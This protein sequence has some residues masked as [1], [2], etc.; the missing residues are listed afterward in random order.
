M[1]HRQRCDTRAALRN[2]R[3]RLVPVPGDRYV[4]HDPIE[5]ADRLE[6][7]DRHRRGLRDDETV[8]VASHAATSAGVRPTSATA[9]P[10]QFWS[11]VAGMTFDMTEIQV[12]TGVRPGDCGHALALE[13]RLRTGRDGVVERP[14]RPATEGSDGGRKVSSG[15]EGT[16]VRVVPVAGQN[17]CPTRTR[18]ADWCEGEPAPVADRLKSYVPRSPRLHFHIRGSHFGGELE[19]IRSDQRHGVAHS[20][21]AAAARS[22]NR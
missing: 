4:D 2:C 13:L 19:A 7:A 3:A 16:E 10:S 5:A 1:R 6:A 17:G 20:P 9:W 8:R 11:S 18:I 15:R 21:M 12:S 14:G 22:L